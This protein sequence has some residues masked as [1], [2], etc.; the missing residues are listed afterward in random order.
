M[1]A[2]KR[3][4]ERNR[5][6]YLPPVIA[7]LKLRLPRVPRSWNWVCIG[8]LVVTVL[9]LLPTSAAASG[10]LPT[11]VVPLRSEKQVKAG[12]RARFF[13][14]ID[15][16]A[17]CSTH[18]ND[19]VRWLNNAS[20]FDQIEVYVD[21]PPRAKP[22]KYRLTV[23][24]SGAASVHLFMTVHSTGH[25]A[26]TLTWFGKGLR[27]FGT[28]VRPLMSEEAALKAHERWLAEGAAILAGYRSGQCTDWAAQKRP[29][30]VQRV[31]E[32]RV[33]AELMR[34]ALPPSLGNAENWASS[35]TAAGMT[36]SE[37][38]ATGALVVWQE[39]VE[40]A[41][42]GTGHIGYVESL[43]PDGSTFSDSSMNVGGLYK[44]GY[45]TRS[46]APVPGRLFIWP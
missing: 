6:C 44:M 13:L 42:P 15:H 16:V 17:T 7:R 10:S 18:L 3:A 37:W 12:D 2:A 14:T 4:R 36:V 45:R 38:P 33:V 28:H 34:T 26:K 1:G 19:S 40:G 32:A 8:A 5:P 43:S 29:D 46:S 31:F 24:C 41:N 23:S 20:R 9:S 35:A 39:G 11:K 30:V 27:V 25:V 22:G 21:V